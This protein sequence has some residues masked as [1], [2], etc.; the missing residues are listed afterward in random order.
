[1]SLPLPIAVTG[2]GGRLGRALVDNLAGQG[3]TIIRAGRPDYDLDDPAAARRLIETHRPGTVIHA[4]AWTDVEGCA[5]QPELALR[6]NA[7]AVQELAEACA[8]SNTTLVLIS[9]NEVFDGQRVD[10]QGYA[11]DDPPQPLNAYGTS[12]LRGELAASA[13]FSG[14][15]G[16]GRLWIIRPAGQRLPEQ[17][18]RRGRSVAG[19][20]GSTRRGR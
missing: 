13:A 5:R 18:H 16:P 7:A 9:T 6:R 14:R 2:P 15:P 19:W 3:E 8:E 11:E 17:D 20:R 1:M 12:K 10:G 4:A